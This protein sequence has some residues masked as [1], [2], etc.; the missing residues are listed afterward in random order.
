MEHAPFAFPNWTN[1]L[2][3][4]DGLFAQA[5]QAL[6]D[7]ER[8]WIKTGIARLYDWYGPRKDLGG[9]DVRQWS[10]G[11]CTRTRFDAVDFTVVLFDDTLFSPAR[12]LAALVPAIAT[13]VRQVMAVRVGD[14]APW[15]EAI[16]TGLELAGQELVIGVGQNQ[17]RRL[18]AELRETDRPGAVA[19]LG[20]KAMETCGAEQYAATRMAFWRPR[21]SRMASVWMEDADSFDLEALAFI[22]PD[23]AFTVYGTKVD[24]PGP[25]FTWAEG[26]FDDFLQVLSDVAY[27]PRERAAAASG[28]AK[29]AL[30]PGLEGSWI[31]PDL[32]ALHFQFRSAAWTIGD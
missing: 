12:L 31:W 1:L 24:F 11:L 14:D 15:R 32:H 10:S 27:L 17:A 23:I 5:Y 4:D 6:S 20:P 22:H 25:N 13:G 2:V 3:P 16:L 26:G 19:V 8:A 28:R 21:F 30:G 18:L 9:E 7:R 29:L